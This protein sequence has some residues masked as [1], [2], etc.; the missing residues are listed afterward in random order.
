MSGEE[1]GIKPVVLYVNGEAV[2]TL[3]PLP[4]T[5]GGGGGGGGIVDQ[6]VGSGLGFVDLSPAMSVT[7]DIAP[8][9]SPS[10]GV[11]RVVQLQFPSSGPYH[12]RL[13][14]FEW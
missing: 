8:R 3:N 9:P 14:D 12:G 6:G 11:V 10:L 1:P 5:G 2:S 13:V 4:A 7:A